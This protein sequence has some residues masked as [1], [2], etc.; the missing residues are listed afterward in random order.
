MAEII[1]NKYDKIGFCSSVVVATECRRDCCSEE[2]TAVRVNPHCTMI[3]GVGIDQEKIG[4]P[5]VFLVEGLQ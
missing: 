1:S 2:K 5:A 4:N 3:N